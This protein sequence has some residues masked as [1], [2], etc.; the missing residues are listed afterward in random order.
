M[1]T[2]LNDFTPFQRGEPRCPVFI[3][4]PAAPFLVLPNTDGWVKIAALTLLPGGRCMAR[5]ELALARQ[6]QRSPRL[7]G[8]E[9]EGDPQRAEVRG[10]AL[11]GT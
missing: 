8:G 6:S 7:G 5:E 10:R 11:S 1:L 2:R 9:Q 3:A 4:T